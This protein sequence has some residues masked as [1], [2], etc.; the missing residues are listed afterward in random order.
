[1]DHYIVQYNASGVTD[2]FICIAEDFDHAKEQCTDA[3]DF[4]NDYEVIDVGIIKW[5]GK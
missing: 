3:Y 5:G 1:M 2:Y 4:I